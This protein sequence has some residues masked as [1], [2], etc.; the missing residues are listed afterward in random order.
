MTRPATASEYI[1]MPVATV[2]GG[3]LK[4]CTMPPIATG[5][6][7]TLKDI[8]AWPSAIATIGSQDSA[9]SMSAMEFA[10]AS[11]AMVLALRIRGLSE[12]GEA[13]PQQSVAATTCI[14]ACARPITLPQFSDPP[15]RCTAL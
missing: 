6:E 10:T 7:A 2:V 5:K 13:G 14:A 9:S 4:L 15:H 1:T 8:N 3:T 12:P 11:D